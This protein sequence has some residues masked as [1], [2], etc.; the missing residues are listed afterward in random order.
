MG[1]GFWYEAGSLVPSIGVGI[2]FFFAL[3]AILRADRREREADREAEQEFRA[4]S[5]VTPDVRTNFHDSS[6]NGN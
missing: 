6:V 5:E 2:L 3:R 1:S 4:A